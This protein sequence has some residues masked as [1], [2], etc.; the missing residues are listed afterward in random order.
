M[1]ILENKANPS[2]QIGTLLIIDELKKS[3]K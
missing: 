3:N 2:M 1:R